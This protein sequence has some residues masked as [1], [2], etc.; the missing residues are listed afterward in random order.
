MPI[1]AGKA[2]FRRLTNEE[3]E[4]LLKEVSFTD[5]ELA[6]LKAIRE[7]LIDAGK[8][9]STKK[10]KLKEDD[11]EKITEYLRDAAQVYVA[12]IQ[13]YTYCLIPNPTDI[14]LAYMHS[15]EEKNIHAA[16]EMLG[17]A[18]TNIQKILDNYSKTLQKGKVLE[19]IK[20]WNT[21]VGKLKTILN[22]RV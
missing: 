14:A 15:A 4:I 20:N 22:R 13:K 12:H 11:A 18:I 6:G 8:I 7:L 17:I 21:K 2:N 1:F 3:I 16:D 9:I 19:G 5:K 10:S